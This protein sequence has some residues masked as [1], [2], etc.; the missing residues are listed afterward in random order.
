MTLQTVRC[1]TDNKD[2]QYH[3]NIWWHLVSAR[4]HVLIFLR[5]PSVWFNRAWFLAQEKIKEWFPGRSLAF[6][7][8]S[9]LE[10]VD[11]LFPWAKCLKDGISKQLLGRVVPRDRSCESWVRLVRRVQSHPS[12]LCEPKVMGRSRKKQKEF[13]FYFWPCTFP[14]SRA[15]CG[16]GI[17]H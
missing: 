14:C 2:N 8:T 10:L 12:L 1:C 16:F 7:W 4:G 5:W 9:L 11:F 17:Q 15:L 6:L 13:I 3:T